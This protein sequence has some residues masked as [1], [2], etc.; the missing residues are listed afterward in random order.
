MRV[1]IHDER[2]AQLPIMT[3]ELEADRQDG[4]EAVFTD[5]RRLATPGHRILDGP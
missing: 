3:G 2:Y 1:S 5:D 4:T